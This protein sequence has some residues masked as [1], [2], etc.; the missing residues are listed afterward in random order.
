MNKNIISHW[1]WLICSCAKA[2]TNGQF[3][4][5]HISIFVPRIIIEL[6]TMSAWVENKGS[7]F[8]KST[9]ETWTSRASW[10]PYNQWVFADVSLGLKQYIMDT[11]VLIKVNIKIPYRYRTKSTRKVSMIISRNS[12]FHFIIICRLTIGQTNN[13]RDYS[14][15]EKVFPKDFHYMLG[16]FIN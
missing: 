5:Q 10:Q 9:K 2:N 16:I 15:A 1:L 14:Y 12:D 4:I 8:V 7:I 13:Y 11:F 3:Q 6:V